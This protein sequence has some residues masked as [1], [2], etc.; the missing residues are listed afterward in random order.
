[1]NLVIYNNAHYEEEQALVDL[2]SGEVIL[3]GDWYHDKIDSVIE[4]YEQALKDFRIITESIPVEEINRNH[5]WYAI[6]DFYDDDYDY[7]E[8]DEEFED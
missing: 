2:E 7:P 1:M 3:K 6:L 4:G 5:K 8:D